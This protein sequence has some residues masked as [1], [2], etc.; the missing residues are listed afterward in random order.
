MC[1]INL[2]T[3]DENKQRKRIEK[4]IELEVLYIFRYLG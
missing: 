4:Q 2:R 1:V 3:I